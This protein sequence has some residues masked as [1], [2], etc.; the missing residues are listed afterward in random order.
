[1]IAC[2]NFLKNSS[3]PSLVPAPYLPHFQSVLSDLCVPEQIRTSVVQFLISKGRVNL[4]FKVF[5]F[6]FNEIFSMNWRL[7]FLDFK[8]H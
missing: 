3:R 4:S 1:M 6:F 5:F 2:F 7:I 8:T